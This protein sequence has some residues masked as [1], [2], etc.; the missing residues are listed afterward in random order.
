[1]GCINK[2]LAASNHQFQT[3]GLTNKTETEAVEFQHI[4]LNTWEWLI[5]V[6]QL[7][8][9]VFPGVDDVVNQIPL[10][11]W[12]ALSSSKRLPIGNIWE[13][14]GN[15]DAPNAPFIAPS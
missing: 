13:Y 6:D 14:K 7:S 3:R 1:M 8:F 5:H 2:A 4:L 12:E 15:M 10:D 9:H 11:G